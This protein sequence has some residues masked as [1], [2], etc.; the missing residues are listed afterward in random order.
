MYTAYSISC[1]VYSISRTV[2]DIQRVHRV[3]YT[4]YRQNI[5]YKNKEEI[6][7]GEKLQNTELN[8]EGA[9]IDWTPSEAPG[10]KLWLD[11]SDLTS[12]PTEWNDKSGQGFN[13]TAGSD[14]NV[15]QN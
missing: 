5:T 13:A 3:Q 1:I 7:L 6:V 12:A 9:V 15:I 4:V 2:Y 14:V 8:S 11:A 10:L